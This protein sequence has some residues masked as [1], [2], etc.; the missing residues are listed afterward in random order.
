MSL[1][2]PQNKLIGIAPPF[3]F[4]TH[5]DASAKLNDFAQSLDLAPQVIVQKRTRACDFPPGST[6]V[7]DH[8]ARVASTVQEL[9]VWLQAVI[10]SGVTVAGPSVLD[11]RDT[12]SRERVQLIQYLGALRSTFRSHRIRE[13]LARARRF[14]T[15][16]GRAGISESIRRRIIAEA[17]SRSVRELSRHLRSEGIEVSKS[18]IAAILKDRRS[19]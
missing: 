16:I 5:E 17:P 4:E 8:V 10:E 14:G 12:S 2:S 9:L 19:K 11:L 7:F 3:L 15:P 13:G 6:V 18:T 1:T